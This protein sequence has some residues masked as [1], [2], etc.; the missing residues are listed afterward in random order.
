MNAMDLLTPQAENLRRRLGTIDT[1]QADLER[2]G[3]FLLTQLE[4]DSNKEDEQVMLRMARMGSVN[5]SALGAAR[6]QAR[7]PYLDAQTGVQQN[8]MQQRYAARQAKRNINAMIPG[9]QGMEIG[10]D[11]QSAV[12]MASDIAGMITGTGGGSKT[13]G[14]GLA[15]GMPGL[16]STAPDELA[17]IM[18]RMSAGVN[19]LGSLP[20]P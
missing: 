2:S 10:N 15:G 17:G 3:G 5:S 1:G 12:S 8:L 19:V 6:E 11:I 7:Q 18:A 4:N 14:Q 9:M 13:Q 16:D 20:L